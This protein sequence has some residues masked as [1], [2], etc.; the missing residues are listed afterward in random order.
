MLIEL[1]YTWIHWVWIRLE[2]SL[3]YKFRYSRFHSFYPL[4]ILLQIQCFWLGALFFSGYLGVLFLMVI[5]IQSGTGASHFLLD[6]KSPN[7]NELRTTEHQ[8]SFFITPNY[9]TLFFYILFSFMDPP[10]SKVHIDV[11]A[12]LR[13][14]TGSSSMS[15]PSGSGSSNIASGSGFG[16]LSQYT[17][18]NQEANRGLKMEPRDSRKKVRLPVQ[19]SKGTTLTGIITH[20][21]KTS[22]Q[23][24][25]LRYPIQYGQLMAFARYFYQSAEVRPNL[26][27]LGK[28]RAGR[29]IGLADDSFPTPYQLQQL[30]QAL[31]QADHINGIALNS[32]WSHQEVL[33]ALRKLFPQIFEYFDVLPRLADGQPHFLVCTK[34]RKDVLVLPDPQP[35]GERLFLNR[36]SK[37]HKWTDNFICLGKQ[38]YLGSP[39]NILIFFKQLP[40]SPFPSK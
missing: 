3:M 32:L 19:N 22:H 10:A 31:M 6:L 14:L 24:T 34:Q 40:A 9:T 17:A 33:T 11:K 4:Q 12:L 28:D 27:S 26:I 38:F 29:V 15:L 1:S 21:K 35:D 23:Q 5:S 16:R 30:P 36:G 25:S 7:Q 39:K 37:K 8:L 13:K 20:R 2:S 18:A